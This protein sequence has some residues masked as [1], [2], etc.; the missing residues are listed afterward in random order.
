MDLVTCT[1]LGVNIFL[2][3]KVKI[4]DNQAKIDFT[5]EERQIDLF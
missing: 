4:P 5:C 2:M 3:N 1:V